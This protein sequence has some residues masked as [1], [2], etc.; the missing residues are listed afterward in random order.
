MMLIMTSLLLIKKL[1]K[2]WL[3]GLYEHS[4]P[5]FLEGGGSN[6]LKYVDELISGIC[7]EPCILG[8]M[9]PNEY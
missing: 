6:N 7:T 4:V 5:I 2:E 9:E 3:I 8:L 1:V